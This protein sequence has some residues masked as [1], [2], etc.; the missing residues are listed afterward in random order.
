MSIT[1]IHIST[2]TATTSAPNPLTEEPSTGSLEES[3]SLWMD[4]EALIDADQLD[5][6]YGRQVWS[7]YHLIGDVLRTED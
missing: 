1:P 5:T 7:N 2:S 4:S 3:V 6:P